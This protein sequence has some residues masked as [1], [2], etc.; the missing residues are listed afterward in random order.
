MGIA[1]SPV[2]GL[3]V[4]TFYP[5]HS[6]TSITSQ[7]HTTIS[8]LTQLKYTIWACIRLGRLHTMMAWAIFP[9]PAIYSVVIWFAIHLPHFLP[10]G[11]PRTVILRECGS[12][13]LRL[14]LV[15]MSY[16]SAGLAWD[17]LIDRS[18]DGRVARTKTRPLPA[19]DV[20]V[21]IACLYIAVQSLAT[22]LLVDGLL[23]GH[24]MRATLIGTAV[25]I[26][27]PFFKRFTSLTQVGGA[28]LIAI[29]VLQ[30]WA[31][32]ASSPIATRIGQEYEDDWTGFASLVWERWDVLAPL[33]VAETLFELYVCEQILSVCTANALHS[34][35]EVV[36][37]NQYTEDDLQLG[38]YSVSIYLG[39]SKSYLCVVGAASCFLWLLTVL[40]VRAHLVAAVPIMLLVGSLLGWETLHL[41]MTK[42]A[43]CGRWAKRGV[44]VKIFLC[45]A[46]P[47]SLVATRA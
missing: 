9:A 2:A 7:K 20:S 40:L 15:I 43:S 36:Y 34:A 47:V 26:P 22:V 25:F 32:C 46:L 37:G 18:F 21:D 19:G 13:L 4:S 30:G 14:T 38:L 33:F 5:A 31:A 39:P 3:T 11:L 44:Q 1:G 28:L 45:V 6:S 29:G 27:Y 41:D 16:R 23:P 35:H 42:P 24:M 12:I 8:P 17:D 10:A